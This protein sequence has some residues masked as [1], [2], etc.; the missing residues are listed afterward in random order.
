ML[1]VSDAAVDE[2]PNPRLFIK[3]LKAL[4]SLLY[5]AADPYLISLKYLLAA[6]DEQ[7]YRNSY[8]NHNARDEL[9]NAVQH[10]PLDG[11]KDINCTADAAKAALKAAAAECELHFDKRLF[12]LSSL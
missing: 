5:D 11:L 10:T 1:E 4:K 9:L 8:L 3:L 6:R 2:I 7:G 12:S